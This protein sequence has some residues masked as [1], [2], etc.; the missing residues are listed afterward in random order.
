VVRAAFQARLQPPVARSYWDF[1]EVPSVRSNL[2]LLG[3]NL[4]RVEGRIADRSERYLNE[5]P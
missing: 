4:A 2:E 3:G 1:Q 5:I